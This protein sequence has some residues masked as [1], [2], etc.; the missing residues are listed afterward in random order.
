[1]EYLIFI[2][3]T[4]LFGIGFFLLLLLLYMKKKMT[5]PFIMMGAGVLLCFA[6]LILAQDFSAT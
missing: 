3:G 6:G 5:V 2:V 4:A 1:M